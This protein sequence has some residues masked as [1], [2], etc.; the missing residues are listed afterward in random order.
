MEGGKTTDIA[1]QR[2]VLRAAVQNTG[3]CVN[4]WT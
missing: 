3:S 1:V 4:T 2:T